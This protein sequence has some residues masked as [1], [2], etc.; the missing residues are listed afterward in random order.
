MLGLGFFSDTLNPIAQRLEHGRQNGRCIASYKL[1][2]VS[3]R[4]VIGRKR[5]KSVQRGIFGDEKA[6]AAITASGFGHKACSRI[7]H[8]GGSDGKKH[9]GSAQDAGNPIETVRLFTEKH[10]IGA[11]NTGDILCTMDGI[12]INTNMNAI[13][14][15]GNPIPGLYVIGNDSGSYFAN[16]YPNLVT[17]MACGRTVTFGRRVGKYLSQLKV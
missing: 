6:S 15:E 11:K 10:H 3:D 4:V 16:T 12:Q 9:I 8:A 1:R 7:D 17:G 2:E 13:D 14:T 5:L